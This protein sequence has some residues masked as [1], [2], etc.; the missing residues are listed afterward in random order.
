[1]ENILTLGKL[2]RLWFC[3]LLHSILFLISQTSYRTYKIISSYEL[4]RPIMG[5]I[6]LVKSL[7]MC[8]KIYLY[9]RIGTNGN[10]MKIRV[11]IVLWTIIR[12]ARNHCQ[13]IDNCG[14]EDHCQY[15][16]GIDH[17]QT[18]TAVRIESTVRM[19]MNM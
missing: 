19:E 18:E 13:D 3:F 16:L 14:D 11:W 9:S 7:G 6:F 15:H 4:A 1:M 12:K 2:L 10:N 5:T 17:C 8:I